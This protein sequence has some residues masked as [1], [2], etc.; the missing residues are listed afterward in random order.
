MNESSKKGKKKK[1]KKERNGK[2]IVHKLTRTVKGIVD[3]VF[4]FSFSVFFR[5]LLCM[6]L[7]LD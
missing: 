4:F 2:Q 1:R 3:F 7:D 5:R 6:E